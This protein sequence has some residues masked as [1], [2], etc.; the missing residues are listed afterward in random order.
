MRRSFITNLNHK[1][2][3]LRNIMDFSGH[4]TMSSLERYLKSDLN[5]SSNLLINM[6]N[7]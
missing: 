3:P 5:E 2:M 4:S 1:G 6:W 7:L